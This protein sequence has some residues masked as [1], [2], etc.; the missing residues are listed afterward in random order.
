MALRVRSGCPS[1][2]DAMVIDNRYLSV[3]EFLQ[4]E[5]VKSKILEQK[6]IDRATVDAM[7][8]A[9]GMDLFIYR[10][11]F[12]LDNNYLSFDNELKEVLNTGKITIDGEEHYID[13]THRN[14]KVIIEALCVDKSKIIKSWGGSRKSRK[15]PKRKTRQQRTRRYRKNNRS[16]E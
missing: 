1:F 10:L 4:D 11:R 7:L 3:K 12:F 8:T 5:R 14:L 13:V 16:I 2:Y 6:G 9:E 15:A